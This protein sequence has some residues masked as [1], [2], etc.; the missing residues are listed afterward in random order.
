[1]V[2]RIQMIQSIGDLLTRLDVLRGGLLPRDPDRRTLDDLRLLLDDRQR[3]LSREQFDEGKH[4]FQS[5][6]ADVARINGEVEQTLDRMERLV[7]TISNLR[8]LL[9]AVDDVLRLAA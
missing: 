5:A 1:M 9:S 3:Q 6:A 8:R 2:T 7:D 4:T